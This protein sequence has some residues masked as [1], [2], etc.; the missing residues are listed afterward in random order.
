ML[1]LLELISKE[2]GLD[3]QYVRVIGTQPTV[4]SKNR[5]LVTPVVA[6]LLPP[7]C[8]SLDNAH[9][10]LAL[11][12]ANSNEVAAIFSAP[13]SIFL[14]AEGHSAIDIE[15]KEEWGGGI[16]RLH[17]FMYNPTDKDIVQG[18]QAPF[19]IWGMTA[20]LCIRTAA[21]VLQREPEFPLDVSDSLTGHL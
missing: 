20:R 12:T 7:A 4:L 8:P 13:L 14:S 10:P 5:L 15:C 19:R 9:L 1:C 2:I 16:I 18:G 6:E 11:L 21:A 17:E 3:R